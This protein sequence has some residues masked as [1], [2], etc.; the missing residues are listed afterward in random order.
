MN[1][2]VLTGEEIGPLRKLCH[3]LGTGLIILVIMTGCSIIREADEVELIQLIEAPAISQKPEYTVVQSTIET[4]V[5]A[6]GRLMSEKQENLMFLDDNKRIEQVLVKPGDPVRAGQVI[7]VIETDKLDTQ[8]R[9]KEIEVR[10]A[11]LKLIDQFRQETGEDS[12]QR[13]LDLLNYEILV[14]DLAEL[15]DQQRRSQLVAPFDGTIVSFT[16]K[17]G[18]TVKAYEKVGVIADLNDLAVAAKFSSADLES[19]VPGMEAIVSINTAGTHQGKVARLPL[20]SS[21][22]D[23]SLESYVIVELDAFPTGLQSGTPLSV[24]VITER[25]ENA[26]LIPPASLRTHAGRNYVQVVDESGNKREVDVEVGLTTATAVEIIS[27]LT[28][29]QKVVGK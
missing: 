14:A 18:D 10:Q 27:G 4:K 25:K 20:N 9:K 11:E 28:P 22:G 5:S 6:T 16:K 8:I 1:I 17:A 29:G 15:N 21:A 24:S 2:R 26:V 23:D 3:L 19:I 12:L 7:A 13:E